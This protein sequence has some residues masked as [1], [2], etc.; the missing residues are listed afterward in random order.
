MS[1]DTPVKTRFAPSP[2][3]AMHLGN[4]RTA[5]FSCL[6]ARHTG[7]TF[8]LRIEDTDQTR[9]TTESERIILDDLSWLGLDWDEGVGKDSKSGPYRQSQR[10]PIYQRLFDALGHAGRTYHCF[11]SPEALAM[12]RKAQMR[13]GRP[14]RYAGTCARLAAD[15][16][17]ALLRDGTPATLRFRVPAGETIA[18]TD[19]VRGLQQ[20][21]TDE[22]GDFVI[23]RA[24]GTAA[25]FFCNAVDDAL[26]GITHVIRGDDHLS[27]T[28]RQ[29]LILNAL[30]LD[31]PQYG[32]VS[33]IVGDDGV[34][35]SKRH[36]ASSV[37]ELRAKGLLPEAICNTL[38]RLGH[39]YAS[40]TFMTLDE[41]AK[42]FD[43]VRLG[44]APAR[45]DEQQLMHWQRESLLRADDD[46][47]LAWMAAAISPYIAE[48][49][50]QLAFA[51]A[52]RGNVLLPE[53]A[54]TLAASL[55]SEA[56]LLSESASTAVKGA[57]SGFFMT[58]ANLVDQ[59][60]TDYQSFI[61]LLKAQTST[62]GKRLFQPLRAALTGRLDGPELAALFPLL[63]AERIR[64][65]LE[66]FA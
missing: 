27:N 39:S 24:D 8:L 58:A 60:G 4:A 22:I 26:M 17:D 56:L 47:L 42:N 33:L 9:N 49:T 30:G 54:Q 63:G 46:R 64:S 14:P 59:C 51:R 3:G 62:K 45:L 13:A 53:D 19:H 16:V 50:Q 32:H 52:V 28:P 55:F 15:E 40:D 6:F 48:Y 65:R 31:A 38:A 21:R 37:E 36:G 7:G 1:A 5:L 2:T 29:L 10:F 23:R 44:S 41:L 57:V 18:F 43:L 20:F 61:S 12:Q 34:P 66:R 25:F 11:C 35:L